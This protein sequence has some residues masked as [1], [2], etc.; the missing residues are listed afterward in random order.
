MSARRGGRTAAPDLTP[1]QLALFEEYTAWARNRGGRWAVQRGICEAD[2]GDYENAALVGL[3]E[4]VRRFDPA[5]GLRFK[6]FAV[7]LVIGRVCDEA[8]NVDVIPRL[9]RQRGEKLAEYFSLDKP[10]GDAH[11]DLRLDLRDRRASPDRR[12][13]AVEALDLEL[14]EVLDAVT[15]EKERRVLELHYLDGLTMKETG[16]A[17]GVCEGRISQICAGLVRKV[18]GRVNVRRACA[19]D[20][21]KL[22]AKPDLPNCLRCKQKMSGRRGVFCQA[23]FTENLQ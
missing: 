18:R 23:C 12:V 11:S 7:P 21:V 6:T 1:A 16:A 3:W 19:A 2:V 5:R 8:R 14:K 13:A 9:V 15:N 20:G 22:P 4:A 10:I 17:L